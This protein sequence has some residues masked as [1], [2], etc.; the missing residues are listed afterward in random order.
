MKVFYKTIKIILK[1][2][3]FKPIKSLKTPLAMSIKIS[4]PKLNKES[5]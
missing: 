2:D 3:K 5:Y 4:K 1:G